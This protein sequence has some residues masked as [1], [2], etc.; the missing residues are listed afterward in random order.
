MTPLR[1]TVILGRF[2]GVPGALLPA[3]AGALVEAAADVDGGP[4]TATEPAVLAG[5]VCVPCED[6]AEL[7]AELEEA[8]SAPEPRSA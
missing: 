3:G 2:T 4:L 1:L 8:D 6:G 7:R 5:V